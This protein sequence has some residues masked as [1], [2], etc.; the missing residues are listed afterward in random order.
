MG[1]DNRVIWIPKR[2]HDKIAVFEVMQVRIV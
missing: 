2:F 1:E